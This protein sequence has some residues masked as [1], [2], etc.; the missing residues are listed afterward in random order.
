MPKKWISRQKC[1]KL[2]MGM[3]GLF[4]ELHP[5]NLGRIHFFC[6]CKDA[7]ILVMISLVVTN[8]AKSVWSAPSI[9]WD[10][11]ALVKYISYQLKSKVANVWLPKYSWATIVGRRPRK[12]STSKWWSWNTAQ[13]RGGRGT[14]SDLLTTLPVEKAHTNTK[15]SKSYCSKT[16]TWKGSYA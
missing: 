1:F 3:V 9:S 7:K 2:Q 10:V 16:W 6:S 12:A 8:L 11:L 5:P 14:I 13:W 15:W 4:F